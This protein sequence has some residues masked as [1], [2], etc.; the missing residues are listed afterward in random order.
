MSGTQP[1]RTL[2]S[3]IVGLQILEAPWARS[4]AAERDQGLAPV[5][6]P[7]TREA[8]HDLFAMQRIESI[9]FDIELIFLARKR[10]YSF[11]IAPIGWSDRQR[12]DDAVP[13]R[14]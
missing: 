10:G 4:V 3:W 8:A 2:P 6:R 14:P 13:N 12:R 7:A 1:Q 5:L 11:V 9:I